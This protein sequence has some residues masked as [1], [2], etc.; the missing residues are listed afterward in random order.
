MF[1]EVLSRNS[2]QIVDAVL[3]GQRLSP[4]LTQVLFDQC[5]DL[6]LLGQLA[7]EVR[8]RLCGDVVYYNIN[9]HINPTNVCGYRCS[10]CAFR[11]S[12]DD[13]TAET[14]DFDAMLSLAQQA[15]DSGCTELHIVGGL[16][17]QKSFDWYVEILRK[18]HDAF[19]RLHLKAFTAV[20]IAHFSRISGLSL[21]RVLGRLIEAGLGSLPGGG[22]EI[23][24]PEVRRQIAPGKADGDLWLDVHRTAHRLGLRSNATMLYGH[25]EQLWHRVDHLLRLRELQDE[26]GGFQAFVPL[27]FHPDGTKLAHLRRATIFDDLRTIAASRLI[28]DN[29][30]HIKAYWVA[31]GVPTA[32]VALTFGAD[33][34]DG[35]VRQERIYHDAGSQAPEVL[36]VS[37]LCRLIRE[38]GREPV[39]RDSL[40]RRVVRQGNHWWIEGE[41]PRDKPIH[42]N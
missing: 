29:F 20:E 5:V 39:E 21:D 4:D 35:T 33:D 22:A 15:A 11:R 30:P 13:P 19:P 18:I 23:F 8:K 7:D 24:A 3:S 41:S 34:L 2:E 40:Y 9:S 12:F 26:T 1:I 36:S 25:V 31:L 10:L 14:M 37:E 28:L 17:P 6:P 32:Q 42:T 16:H 27:P 38:V